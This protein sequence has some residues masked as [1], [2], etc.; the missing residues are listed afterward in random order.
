M[1][2]FAK[3]NYNGPDTQSVPTHLRKE[4]AVIQ[5]HVK[6]SPV[7]VALFLTQNQDIAHYYLFI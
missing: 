2:P 3:E 7:V 6:K 5:V 1:K 4:H